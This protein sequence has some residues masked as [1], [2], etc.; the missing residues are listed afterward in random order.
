MPCPAKELG[1]I[2]PFVAMFVAISESQK[3]ICS[4]RFA[5]WRGCACSAFGHGMPCPYCRKRQLQKNDAG[6]FSTSQFLGCSDL[7]H[8]QEWLCYWGFRHWAKA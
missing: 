3:S 7:G 1:G 4:A 6:A 8:S 2:A 5:R